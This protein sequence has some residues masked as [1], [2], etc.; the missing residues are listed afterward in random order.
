M[1]DFTN[2]IVLITGASQGI[3]LGIAQGFKKAGA[4]VH[5]TGT[6]QGIESYNDDLSGFHYHQADLRE[7]DARVKLHQEIPVI[8]VLVNNAAISPEGQFEVDQFRQV[9]E[10]NLIGVMELCT[11]YRQV[12]TE[13]G[14]SIVNVGSLSS[15]LSLQDEPAYTSSKSGLFGLTRVLADKWA[16]SGLRVNMIAPGFVH[17]QLTDRYRK[18][19]VYE[20]RLL[21]AVPMKRWAEPS[22][23]AGG[24]MFLASPLASYI[25]GISLPI[26]GGVMLR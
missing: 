20:K 4:T 18:D 2:K 21:A 25:T 13:R 15:H 10:M 6:R 26:D 22:E 1:L 17:T 12:L 5:I 14:G 16:K 23:M 11:A 24:V 3:G 7:S 8:D 19:P 9:I